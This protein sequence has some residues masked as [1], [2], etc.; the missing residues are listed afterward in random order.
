MG[1][2]LCLLRRPFTGRPKVGGQLPRTHAAAT[3]THP[4]TLDLDPVTTSQHSYV[5][6]ACPWCHRATLAHALR[7]LAQAQLSYSYA[8]DDPEKAS[9]GGWAFEAGDDKHRDPVFGLNDLREVYDLLSPGY[10]GR[11]TAPV[12]VDR[13]A[14]RVVSNESSEIVRMLN[15]LP[16]PPGAP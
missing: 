5:G 12:L 3:H 11:C 10:R 15:A 6:N 16:P 4:R 2:R 7:G 1:V 13:K 9:R 8:I 14:R